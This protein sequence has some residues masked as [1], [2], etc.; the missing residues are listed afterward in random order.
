MF[1]YM[2]GGGSEGA[3]SR[4]FAFTVKDFAR[5]DPG[6]M[7]KNSGAAYDPA[8]NTITLPSMGQYIEVKH[9]LGDVCFA[10]TGH[11]PVWAWRL[12]VLNHLCRASG[13][14]VAGRPVSYRELE[15]GNVFYPAFLRESINPLAEKLSRESPENINK[16]C[17]ELGGKLLNLADV[18]SVFEFLPKFPVTVKIWLKDEEMEGSANI[19]FDASANG[20]LHTE[21]VAAAGNLVSYFLI[22]QYRLMFGV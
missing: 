3:Y 14:A 11:Q 22:K 6:D 19:L 15:N 10:D 21:D 4:T 18:S 1:P 12:I 5:K 8:K 13:E 7:A 16:A 20:Y 9:P 2:I 17:L